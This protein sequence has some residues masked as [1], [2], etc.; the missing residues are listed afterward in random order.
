MK[1]CS[2]CKIKKEL[3]EFWKDKYTKDWLCPQCI[4]CRMEAKIKYRTSINWKI[5]ENNYRI[6]YRLK[7]LKEE[8]ERHKLYREKNKE[9]LRIQNLEYVRK[10]KDHINQ[11]RKQR[12]DE[13]FSIW[14]KIIYNNL[15]WKIK[16]VIYWRW[17]LIQ[18]ENWF[19]LWIWKHKL[20]PFKKIKNKIC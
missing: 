14:R 5:K 8:K 2:R 18:F 13:Y 19:L 10:N 11:L 15:I 1:I 12:E 7:H 4:F 20:K 6:L 3:S 9:K 17:C 16:E